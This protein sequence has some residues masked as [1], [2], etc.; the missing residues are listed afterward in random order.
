[1]ATRLFVGAAFVQE[2]H[3]H[4]PHLFRSHS[5]P[6]WSKHVLSLVAEQDEGSDSRDHGT[7]RRK[8]RVGRQI[9][10]VRLQPI[11]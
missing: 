11:T 4:A 2:G 7:T 6:F 5:A 9:R 1:M 10:L 3:D 8:A